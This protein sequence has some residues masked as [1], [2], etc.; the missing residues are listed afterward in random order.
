MRPCPSFRSHAA[1]PGRAAHQRYSRFT[2]RFLI[3][4]RAAF[5]LCF[6]SGRARRADYECVE[7]GVRPWA[8]PLN[9]EANRSAESD[10]R[11]RSVSFNKAD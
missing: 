11:R 4:T 8:R 7:K 5:T 9:S 10:L 1:M 6:Y 3:D 2:N